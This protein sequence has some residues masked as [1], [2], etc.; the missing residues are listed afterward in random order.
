MCIIVYKLFGVTVL[1]YNIIL[2]QFWLIKVK[3]DL[4][5]ILLS[6]FFHFTMICIFLFL[7]VS[8]I[9]KAQLYTLALLTSIGLNQPGSTHKHIL[10][11]HPAALPGADLCGP[12]QL[13]YWKVSLELKANSVNIAFHFHSTVFFKLLYWMFSSFDTSYYPK[14]GVK[15]N[16]GISRSHNHDSA[17]GNTSSFLC[18]SVFDF[19]L[20]LNNSY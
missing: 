4:F 17:A 19:H 7:I 14:F 18:S 3:T 2:R 12:Q 15:H 6:D 11:T 1:G 8:L 13:C 20:T 5:P 9:L 16:K 10:Q